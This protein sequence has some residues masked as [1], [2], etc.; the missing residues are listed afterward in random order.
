M[1]GGKAEGIWA[2]C[3]KSLEWTCKHWLCVSSSQQ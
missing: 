3:S 1:A 2:N